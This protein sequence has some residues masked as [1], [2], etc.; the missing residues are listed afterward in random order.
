MA[1]LDLAKFLEAKVNAWDD[2][3]VVKTGRMF[4]GEKINGWFKTDLPDTH[5]D[6]LTSDDIIAMQQMQLNPRNKE[7]RIQYINS[8]PELYSEFCWI[9]HSWVTLNDEIL[10][11]SGFIPK[12]GGQFTKF[13]INK[14][15]LASRYYNFS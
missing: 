14:N 3:Y 2:V 15:N 10:D 5:E 11:P 12:T 9:P 6:A 13:L 4:D 7:S 1:S 8:S